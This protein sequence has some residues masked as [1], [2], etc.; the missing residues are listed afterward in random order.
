MFWLVL[1]LI[2]FWWL[3][4]KFSLAV[5]NKSSIP[6]PNCIMDVDIVVGVVVVVVVVFNVFVV[7][8]LVV[9]DLIIF[10]CGQ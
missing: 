4:F 7:A 6:T 2:L 9:A 5:V 8:L 10:S 3:L 1:L